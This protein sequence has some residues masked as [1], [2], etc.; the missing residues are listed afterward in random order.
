M[1]TRLPLPFLLLCASMIAAGCA[2]PPA[3]TTLTPPVPDETEDA[4]EAKDEADGGALSA[5]AGK[6]LF[7]EALFEMPPRVGMDMTATREGKEVMA[8]RGFLDNETGVSW[9]RMKLDPA[10]MG[11]DPSEVPP[12]MGAMFQEGIEVYI[13]PKGSLY[14][15]DGAAFV[16]PPG[17]DETFVPKPEQ[18]PLMAF[19][20]GARR[21]GTDEDGADD[22]EVLSVTPTTHRGKPA[23]RMEMRQTD[24]N[25]TSEGTLVLLT[26]PPRIAHMEMTVPDQA[27]GE[28]N[29]M[30]GAR[31]VLDMLYDDEVPREG[32]A[33]AAR[34]LA[35]A[36]EAERDMQG[37]GWDEDAVMETTWTFV[38]AGGI[39]LSEVEVVLKEEGEQ[40]FGDDASMADFAALPERWAMKL[41]D[42]QRQDG[43]VTVTYNDLDG[44]GKVSKGDTVHILAPASE[45]ATFVLRDATTGTY[46]V[47]GPGLAF[48]LVLV[49]L[50]AMAWRKAK[51]GAR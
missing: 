12:S 20:E 9:F 48:G 11:A 15:A 6:A 50:A 2:E 41:S 44:D 7:E 1:A 18:S 21:G 17:A 23:L 3:A 19:F 37:S 24:E 36:Y 43:N 30:Y 29:P 49:G 31:V 33:P 8:M 27:S 35:L 40:V 39:P 10:A 4:T 38:G 25:G 42:G 47:P 32:P 13:T 34:A 5:A 16:F 26:S 46:V 28:P 14:L 45:T 51:G 22:V